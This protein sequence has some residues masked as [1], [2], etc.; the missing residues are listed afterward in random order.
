MLWTTPKKLLQKCHK[1]TD[2]YLFLYIF[3][4]TLFEADEI[5]NGTANFLQSVQIFGTNAED[6]K[7]SFEEEYKIFKTQNGIRL[8]PAQVGGR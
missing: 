4:K 1:P 8:P 2:L 3:F 7:E 6:Q 5:K